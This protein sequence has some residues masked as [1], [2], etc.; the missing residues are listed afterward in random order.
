MPADIYAYW[1]LAQ[2]QAP[3]PEPP[4]EYQTPFYQWEP[5]ELTQQWHPQS[6]PESYIHPS[7]STRDAPAE[8]PRVEIPSSPG[9]PAPSEDVLLRLPRAHL[10]LIDRRRSLPVAAVKLNPCHYSFSL[11][12]PASPDASPSPAASARACVRVS[13]CCPLRPAVDEEGRR[14]RQGKKKKEVK[15]ETKLGMAYKKDDNFG[16][17]YSEIQARSIPHLLEGRD[18]MG[19]AK[20]GSGKTLAFLI[21]ATELLYNL[22]FSPR[23][24]T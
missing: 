16:E 10:H 21:P 24:G 9:A 13:C 22:H 7:T 5:E 6:A 19:A 4:V 17:W 3:V 12:I 14:P 1:G 15:K 20:T 8:P 11:T 2:P 23:N 18:V